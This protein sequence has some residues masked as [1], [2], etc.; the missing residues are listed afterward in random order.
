MTW[1]ICEEIKSS[2]DKCI[3][4]DSDILQGCIWRINLNEIEKIEFLKEDGYKYGSLNYVRSNGKR[5][6]WINEY[7]KMLK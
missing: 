6:N 1:K 3:T 5:I 2:F 7:Y 4:K